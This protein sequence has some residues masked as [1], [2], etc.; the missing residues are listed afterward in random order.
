[1][2]AEITQEA[3]D[4]NQRLPMLEATRQTLKSAGIDETPR[5]VVADTGYWNEAAIAKVKAGE[6][7]FFINPFRKARGRKRKDGAEPK[8]KPPTPSE[9]K[10]HRDRAGEILKRRGAMVEGVFGQIKTVQGATRF[11][12][13]GIAACASEWKLICAAHNLLKIWRALTKRRKEAIPCLAAS[14]CPG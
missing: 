12:R 7:E 8:K 11:M 4:Q 9:E 10:M 1:V 6:T 2:E 3:N 5:E 14:P 13:R